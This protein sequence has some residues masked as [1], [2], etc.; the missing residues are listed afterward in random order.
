[1][2]RLAFWAFAVAALIACMSLDLQGEQFMADGLRRI[3]CLIP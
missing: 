2:R 3:T 1:M